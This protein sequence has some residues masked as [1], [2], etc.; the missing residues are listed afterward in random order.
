MNAERSQRRPTA[1][2]RDEKARTPER[3]GHGIPT[4]DRRDETGVGAGPRVC[5]SPRPIS[6]LRSAWG[7]TVLDAPA[8]VP[9]N[10]DGGREEGTQERPGHPRPDGGPSGRDRC[11]GTKP[12]RRETCRACIPFG[13]AQGRLCTRNLAPIAG[14]IPRASMHALRR[15]RPARA[16][17]R[18]RMG[19]TLGVG[20]RRR[21]W[22]CWRRRWSC[23]GRGSS[24]SRCSVIGCRCSGGR[25]GCRLSVVGS[26]GERRRG[27][28]R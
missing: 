23:G 15:S 2:R 14:I 18:R 13:F 5:P 21:L 28:E 4:G 16:A 10:G 20:I 17:R 12:P 25:A 22:R 6:S 9:S 19:G 7:R 27:C 3:P 24:S 1:E 11:R 26:R 8:S